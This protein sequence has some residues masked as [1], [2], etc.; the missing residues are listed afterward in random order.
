MNASWFNSKQS[1]RRRDRVELT[2][3]D[4][5]EKYVGVAGRRTR[6]IQQLA[7]LGHSHVER[8]THEPT[9]EERVRPAA[10]S[11]RMARP[12]YAAARRRGARRRST[13]RPPLRDPLV[14]D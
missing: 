14:F 13:S 11:A 7:A 9:R 2:C 12:R 4:P 5:A 1:Q 8:E 6:G 10:A 3:Q